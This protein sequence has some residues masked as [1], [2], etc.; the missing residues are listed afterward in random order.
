[1]MSTSQACHT[2]GRG[3]YM[4]SPENSVGQNKGLGLSPHPQE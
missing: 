3:S 2:H 1:M 4:G